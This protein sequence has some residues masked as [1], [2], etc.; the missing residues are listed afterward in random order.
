MGGRGKN[1]RGGGRTEW[2]KKG[3]KWERNGRGRGI[4]LVLA[5]IPL[6]RNPESNTG[7]YTEVEKPFNISPCWPGSGPPTT[8]RRDV[9]LLRSNDSLRSICGL[10]LGRRPMAFDACNNNNSDS[11]SRFSNQTITAQPTRIS[12]CSSY[13]V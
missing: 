11:F 1:G 12:R 9:M 2:A 3:R 5:Y 7:W 10:T 13:E 6:V 8:L 4:H